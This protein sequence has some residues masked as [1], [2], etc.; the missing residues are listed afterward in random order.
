M[1]GIRGRVDKG[2][3]LGSV[4]AGRI[5][6][7][8]GKAGDEEENVAGD[9]IYDEDQA[10]TVLETTISTHIHI[11]PKTSTSTISFVM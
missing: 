11:T 1:E 10:G 9:A 6:G 2:Q 3:G 8:G 4:N 5:G 7:G